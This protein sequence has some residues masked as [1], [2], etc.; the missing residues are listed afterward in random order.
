MADE[1]VSTLTPPHDA[2]ASKVASRAVLESAKV[3]YEV[4]HPLASFEAVL[5]ASSVESV[6]S[7]NDALPEELAGTVLIDLLGFSSG[8]RARDKHA[9]RSLSTDAFPS[10]QLALR[11]LKLQKNMDGSKSAQSRVRGQCIAALSLHGQSRPWPAEVELQWSE[12]EL[13]LTSTFRILL[14]DFS[15]PRDK[16]FGVAIR[17]E[18]PISVELRYRRD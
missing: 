12:D 2:V 14:D 4:S 11:G 18:V 7:F 16:L 5:D 9:R 13:V 1:G 10:A 6:L 8:N 15:I 17:N 3:S